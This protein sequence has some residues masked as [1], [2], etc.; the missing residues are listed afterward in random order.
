VVPRSALFPECAP[1]GLAVFG[2]EWSATRFHEVVRTEGFFVERE[3][4]ETEPSLKQII[5]YTLVMRGKEILLLARTKGGGESRLHNKLSIGVGGHVN[6]VDAI[7]PED[8][9][10]RL[11]DPLPA[12]TRREVMEEELEV[13]GATRLTPVGLINDDTNAVG[14]VHVGLVQILELLDGDARVREVDQLE[15]S[16]VSLAELRERAERGDRLETWSS[17][18]VPRLDHALELLERAPHGAQTTSEPSLVKPALRP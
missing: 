10:R 11:S 17:L 9:G 13:T 2:G 15:G 3:Y 8:A 1:H 4:A 18:L 6:P 14:A 5:P 12:A 7:D 16:F